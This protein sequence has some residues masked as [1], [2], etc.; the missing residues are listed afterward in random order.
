MA[1][2]IQASVEGFWVFLTKLETGSRF[3]QAARSQKP[4]EGK[5]EAWTGVVAIRARKPNSTAKKTEV[6]CAENARV[7]IV[8]AFIVSTELLV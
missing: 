1:M 4:L 6:T 7:A 2:Y 8:L 3:A 5:T